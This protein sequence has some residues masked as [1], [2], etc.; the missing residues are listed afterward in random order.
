MTTQT[1]H[2]PGPW[3]LRHEVDSDGKHHDYV[4]GQYYIAEILPISKSQQ[5]M[6]DANARLI[7]AAPEQNEAL[8]AIVARINGDFDHLAL[9]KY[10]P[11]SP[12]TESDCL[13]IAQAAI[14]KARGEA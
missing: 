4:R 7:A 12:N 10:G 14:A 11:L 8:Q 1:K 3:E 13:F 5:C 6:V 2:T 9:L